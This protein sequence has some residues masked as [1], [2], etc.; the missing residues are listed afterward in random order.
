MVETIIWENSRKEQEEQETK[1]NNTMKEVKGDENIDKGSAIKDANL[2]LKMKNG[3]V[4]AT[5]RRSRILV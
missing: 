4:K 5:N 1:K 2:V 3:K